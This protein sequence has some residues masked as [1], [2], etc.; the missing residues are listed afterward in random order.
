MMT[1]TGRSKVGDDGGA[2]DASAVA[3]AEPRQHARKI[4]SDFFM[5]D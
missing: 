5:I 4:A 3:A 1:I 2:S